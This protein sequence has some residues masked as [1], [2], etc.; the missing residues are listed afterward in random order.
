M[1]F[2]RK[3]DSLPSFV[4]EQLHETPQYGIHKD[5]KEFVKNPCKLVE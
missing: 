5:K 4:T 3:Y 2:L 1:P